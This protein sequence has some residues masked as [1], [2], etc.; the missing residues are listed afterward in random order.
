MPS[1][2]EYLL[3]PDVRGLG[4]RTLSMYF[5]TASEKKNSSKPLGV[6]PGLDLIAREQGSLSL[7]HGS[8]RGRGW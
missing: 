1:W 3:V 8:G 6:N 2:T 5:W 7:L 4:F